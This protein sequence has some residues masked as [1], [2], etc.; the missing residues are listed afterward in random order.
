[1]RRLERFLPYA[2]TGIVG[3]LLLA[4]VLNLTIL[5][6]DVSQ[7]ERTARANRQAIKR[8]CEILNAAI[9]ESQSSQGGKPTQ[10]LIAAILDGKPQVKAAYL[11]AAKAEGPALKQINCKRVASDPAYRPYK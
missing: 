1:M 11:K 6:G 2:A 4:F 9:V 8:S 7:T 3:G 10:I 5:S